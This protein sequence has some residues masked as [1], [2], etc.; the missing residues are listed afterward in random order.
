MNSGKFVY[1]TYIAVAP[2]K[3]FHALTDREATRAYW[4]HIN[5]SDWKQ[6]SRWEHQRPDES[7]TADIVGTVLE[8]EPPLRLVLSW[9]RPRDEGNPEM[10]SRV[11]FEI[12]RYQD[13]TKLT[14]IHENLDPA[15]EASVA[16]GWPKVLANLKSYLETGRTFQ[17]WEQA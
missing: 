9:S 5:D 10:A 2:E 15:M 17:L 8:V 1:V 11:T 12:E 4:W 7:K 3:V 14:V 13:A 16:G 6:G